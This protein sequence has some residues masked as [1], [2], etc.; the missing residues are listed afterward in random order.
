MSPRVLGLDLSITAT[1]V[2]DAD[3][4]LATLHPR[5]PGDER[6]RQLRDAIRL[7]AGGCP[8]DLAVIED[9]PTHARAAGIT[10][11]VHGV[12]RS[13]LLDAGVPYA[14]A[15]PASL[16]KYATGRGNATKADMRMELYKRAGLDICDDNQVDAYW[17]RAMG[18]HWLGHPQIK[19]PVGRR[20][21]LD[22]VRWPDTTRERTA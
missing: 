7:A 19:L 3:G 4:H 21:A 22:K 12:A 20:D 9:L 17:L 18:L 8:P 14:L 11:M 5:A 13:L 15:S 6:L 2:A 10:G 1:G 16:K